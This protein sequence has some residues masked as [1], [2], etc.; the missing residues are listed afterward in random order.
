M[1]SLAMII[2]FLDLGDWYAALHLQDAHFHMVMHLGHRKFL[3]FIVGHDHYPFTVLP[4]S[5][6][7][8]LSV[9]YLELEFGV[10]WTYGSFFRTFGIVLFYASIGKGILIAIT[11]ARRI[12]ELSVLVMDP[13]CTVLSKD[14]IYLSLHPKFFSKVVYDFHIN[15]STH[16][17]SF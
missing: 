2:R 17:F 3:R 9:W 15:Q 13:P 12:G 6:L 4:F 11:L 16:Q 1:F 14:K 8:L 10:F 5:V 7:F